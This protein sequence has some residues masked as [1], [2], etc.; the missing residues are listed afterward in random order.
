M[1]LLRM[2]TTPRAGV[3]FPDGRRQTPNTGAIFAAFAVSVKFMV[4]QRGEAQ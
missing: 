4:E 2:A 1:A 3:P